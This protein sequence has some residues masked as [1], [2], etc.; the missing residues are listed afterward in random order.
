MLIVAFFDIIVSNVYNGTYRK[1]AK[2]RLRLQSKSLFTYS[3][4][5]FRLEWAVLAYKLTTYSE[6]MSKML[7]GINFS[8]FEIFR[9]LTSILEVNFFVTHLKNVEIRG[10]L[11]KKPIFTQ[12]KRS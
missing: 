4:G 12:C 6:S 3:R 10:T 5:T 11:A 2:N 1:S 7:Y 9:F 8:F